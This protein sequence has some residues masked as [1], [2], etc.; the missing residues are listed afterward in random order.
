LVK[1]VTD[2]DVDDNV[3]TAIHVFTPHGF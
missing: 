3:M 2:C 1:G